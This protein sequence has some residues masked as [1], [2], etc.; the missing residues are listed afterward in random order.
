MRYNKGRSFRLSDN[1]W[2]KFRALKKRG[3]TWE[4]FIIKL[5]KKILE[6][7]LF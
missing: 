7:K 3:Q 5:L 2:A 1:T 6:D 4:D